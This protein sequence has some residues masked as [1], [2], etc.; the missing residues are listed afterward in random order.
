MRDRVEDTLV[1]IAPAVELIAA[2]RGLLTSRLNARPEPA[3][4]LDAREIFESQ[5]AC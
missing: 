5:P 4:H 2:Y 1:Q 3:S